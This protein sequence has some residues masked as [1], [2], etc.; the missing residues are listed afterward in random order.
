MR[1][2]R[3]SEDK[4]CP[5]CDSRCVHGYCECCEDVCPECMRR[6][7]LEQEAD[8][9]AKFQREVIGPMFGW[10]DEEL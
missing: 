3:E 10:S 8:A 2:F 9:E 5:Q 1:D 4:Q 6:W 7:N